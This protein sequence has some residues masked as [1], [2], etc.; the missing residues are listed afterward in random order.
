MAKEIMQHETDHHVSYLVRMMFSLGQVKKVKKKI[1][2]TKSEDIAETVIKFTFWDQN[3]ERQRIYNT[4]IIQNFIYRISAN[5][6]RG[7]Y[8]FLNLTLGSMT[9]GYSTFRCG[10]YSREE[11]IRGNTVIF[12]FYALI[13]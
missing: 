4:Y 6:F 3:L 8:S 1:R 10:N 11:T 2:M 5:S 13:F 7:N 12:L 9:F